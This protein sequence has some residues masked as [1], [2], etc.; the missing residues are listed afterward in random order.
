MNFQAP[1][2][3][4]QDGDAARLTGMDFEVSLPA[5]SLAARSGR[6]EI[7]ELL[8]QRLRLHRDA[9]LKDAPSIAIAAARSGHVHILSHLWNEGITSFSPMA[10]GPIMILHV[11]VCFLLPFWNNR[12]ICWV[13]SRTVQNTSPVLPSS[14]WKSRSPETLSLWC[15]VSGRLAGWVAVQRFMRPPDVGV[16]T[17]FDG[18][19]VTALTAGRWMVMDLKLCRWRSTIGEELTWQIWQRLKSQMLDQLAHNF[20][21]FFCHFEKQTHTFWWP[22]RKV[23]KG[24]SRSKPGVSILC[25]VFKRSGSARFGPLPFIPCYRGFFQVLPTSQTLEMIW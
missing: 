3:C 18:S 19:C 8:L 10:Y 11:V 20:V 1:K 14:F 9:T 7:L 16:L 24:F 4:F 23:Q 17:S 25:R 13:F 2:L 15:Q 5:L 21:L 22:A 12:E 6:K